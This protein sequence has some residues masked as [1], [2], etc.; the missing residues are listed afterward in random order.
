[1]EKEKKSV[2]KLVIVIVALVLAFALEGGVVWA[3][4]TKTAKAGMATEKDAEKDK[5]DKKDKSD[6]EK[7]EDKDD[8][9][10]DDEDDDEEEEEGEEGEEGSILDLFGGLF[11][12]RDVA[13]EDDV[14]I[15]G[16]YVIKSTKDISDAYISGDDS[17]LDDKQKET[18]QMASDVLDEIITDDM[19]NYEKELAVYEWI[20]D[21]IKHDDSV[22]V[23]IR[24]LSNADNPYG[25]LKYRKAVC[26]GYA[27][28]FRLLTN[29]LGFDCMV[30]HS[31]DR[32][33]SWGLIKLDD[34][35][36]YHCDAYS[37]AETD[38]LSNFNQN[39][40][41]R[42]GWDW[43]KDFFP[44]GTGTEYCYA[45]MGAVDFTDYRDIATRMHDLIQ[46]GASGHFAI[47]FAEDQWDED[48]YEILSCLAERADSYVYSNNDDAYA[49]W[50]TIEAE[51]GAYFTY[52]FTVYEY[53]ESEEEEWEE[54]EYTPTEAEIKAQEIIGDVFSDM[55]L[56]EDYSYDYVYEGAVG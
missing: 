55:E 54:E 51:E 52:D 53:E 6:K 5:K 50:D 1:M 46:T 4:A 32:V 35:N 31:S 29:M 27:T 28:T 30:C 33:H 15:A 10:E 26:V 16:V 24:G 44:E 11:G 39:D 12:N 47:K 18:L 9:D 34:G 45:F 14:T 23:A 38:S 20:R 7:D 8:E 48:V 36:W 40:Y 25:V 13:Q 19:T 49:S 2:K 17:A 37:D 22:T 43:N 56:S 41:V 42:S 21:N 3:V